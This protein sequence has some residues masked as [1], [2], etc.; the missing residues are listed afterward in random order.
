MNW[1]ENIKKYFDNKLW[2]VEMV[3][4]AV[5]KG[6]ITELEFEEITK[7]AESPLL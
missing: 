4:N 7:G 6:K 1:F 2:T 5:V 3:S